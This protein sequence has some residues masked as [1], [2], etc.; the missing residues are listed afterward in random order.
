MGIKKGIGRGLKD[1]EMKRKGKGF[2]LYK[3]KILA[4]SLR[5]SWFETTSGVRPL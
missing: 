3:P 4:A 1:V 2:S 5:G